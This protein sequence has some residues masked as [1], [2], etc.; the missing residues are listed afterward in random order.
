M[1]LSPISTADLIALQS[2]DLTKVS[3]QGLQYLHDG[4]PPRYFGSGKSYDAVGG[5][6]VPTGSPQAQ[7]GYSPIDA[8]NP[9]SRSPVTDEV[10]GFL[11]NALAGSGARLTDMGLAAQ[12]I[13]GVASPQDAANKRALDAPVNATAGGRFGQL[14]T[15]ALTAVPLA[16]IPGI[17]TYGGA[18]AMGAAYG[19]LTPVAGDESRGLNTGVGAGMGIVSQSGGNMLGKWLTARSASTP[20]LTGSQQSAADAGEALGMQLTPGQRAGSTSLQQLESKF[21]SQPWS[22]GPFNAVG[23]ANQE[24]LNGAW[25]RDGRVFFCPEG[26]QYWRYKKTKHQPRL[27]YPNRGTV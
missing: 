18:A 2:G 14:A 9:N 13:L 3:D 8:S 25:A 15:G 10:T 16:G 22:S 17:A 1:D 7:A 20:G 27:K 6:L 12:Q 21:A 26:L 19:A 4:T 24:A 11:R 5:Q 23:K